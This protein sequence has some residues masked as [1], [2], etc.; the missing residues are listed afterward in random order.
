LL[1]LCSTARAQTPPVQYKLPVGKKLVYNTQSATDYGRGKAGTAQQLEFWVMAM[2]PDSSYHVVLERTLRDYRTTPD[3]KWAEDQPR[4]DWAWCDI[5]ANGRIPDNSSLGDMAP[6]SVF[7]PLPGDTASAQS[8]WGRTDTAMGEHITY[9]IEDGSPADSIWVV[10][11]GKQTPLDG[12]YEITYRGEAKINRSQGLPLGENVEYLQGYGSVSTQSTTTL[13]SIIPLDPT[14]LKDFSPQLATLLQAEST[15]SDLAG[16]AGEQPGAATLMLARADS[17]LSQALSQ[18]TDSGLR[19]TLHREVGEYANYAAQSGAAKTQEKPKLAVGQQA[20]DWQLS[21]LDGKTH[22]LKSYK[23][24]VLVLDFWYRACP[25]CMRA[26]PQI[27]QVA[28]HFKGRPVQ[29]LGMNVDRDTADARFVINK[30]QLIYPS[31]KATGVPEKY[32]VSGFPTMFVIG[33]DGIVRDIDIGYTPDVGRKLTGEI[34]K[35]LSSK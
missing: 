23:G 35:L 11:I 19:T 7:I 18:V 24:K 27:N 33:R 8:G 22:S 28:A 9:H 26:M 10:E 3:G 16:K 12:V 13:D 15:A 1:L 34:E 5:Y 6:S 4:M 14:Q 29:I 21:D 20:P 17:V 30:L 32:G 25:W 31:L 2:N